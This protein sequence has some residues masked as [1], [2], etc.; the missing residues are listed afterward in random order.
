MWLKHSGT[1]LALLTLMLAACGEDGAQTAPAQ[2]SSQQGGAVEVGIQVLQAQNIDLQVDLPGRTSA[3]EAAEIR[4]QVSGIIVER[5]FEEGSHVEKGQ[6]LYQIDPAT[7]QADYNTAAAELKRAQANLKSVSSQADRYK[8]LVEVNAV[9]RQQYDDIVANLGVAQAEISMAKASVNRAQ[10]NLDYTKVRAPITGRIGKSA[11]TPGALVTANQQNPLALVQQYDPMYV[12]VSQSSSE[13]MALREK[14]EKGQVEGSADSAK[15]ELILDDLGQKYPHSGTL[16]FSDV[17]VDTTT[18]NVQIRAI[19]PN[20]EGTLLPGLFVRTIVTQGQLNNALL[21]PQQSVVRNANGQAMAW[22]V[23]AEN[24]AQMVPV[25]TAQ[26]IGD[27]WVVTKGLQSGDK[28]I[29]QGAIKVQAGVAVKPVDLAQEANAQ[30]ENAAAAPAAG[31]EPAEPQESTEPATDEAPQ[32]DA[33]T[34]PAAENA[35]ET[36]TKE[37]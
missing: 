34:E 28:V 30:K 13:M 31:A 12:D 9:S 6:Q 27:K 2:Q 4:P 18:G 22:V 11:V 1:L 5:L 29:L 7:Y 19:F 36:D 24:K 35:A 8:K 21:V 25:E 26:A 17:T 15:V 10:I 20:P 32:Q 16:K 3:F 37:E 33:D 14:I 23:D